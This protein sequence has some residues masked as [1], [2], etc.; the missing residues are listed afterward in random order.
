MIPLPL[1]ETTKLEL[2]PVHPLLSQP[3]QVLLPLPLPQ[4]LLPELLATQEKLLVL[5]VNATS[6]LTA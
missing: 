4:L 1:T 6:L 2:K 5:M 3:L